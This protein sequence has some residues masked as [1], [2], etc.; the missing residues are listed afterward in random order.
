M[1]HSPSSEAN[2][3]SA[4]QEIPYI[5][6]NPKV[7]YRIHNNLPAVPFLT[8]INPVYALRSFPEHPY[9]YY[10]PIYAWAFQMFSFLQVSPPKPCIRLSSPHTCY[11]PSHQI[12]LGLNTR[13]IFDEQYRSL[14]PSLCIFL[15]YPVT[16]SLL[17]PNI[18]TTPYSQTLST[19]VPLSMWA[20]KFHTHTKQQAKL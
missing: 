17:G 5:L 13:T 3:F 15:H 9:L 16:T 11:M 8:H 19:Y 18:L 7:H 6:W 2:W 14:S 12:F 1:Q 10:L 20:T 4:I